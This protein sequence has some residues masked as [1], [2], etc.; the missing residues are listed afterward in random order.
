ML[1]K[2]MVLLP[3]QIE[4]RKAG[5]TAEIH[6]WEMQAFERWGKEDKIS[7]RG[8]NGGILGM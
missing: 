2:G 4:V 5:G 3:D 7:T 6:F 1:L 8:T